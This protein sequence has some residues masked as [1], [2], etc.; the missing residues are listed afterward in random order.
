MVSTVHH[1]AVLYPEIGYDVWRLLWTSGFPDGV[2]WVSF[3][4]ERG[5]EADD[6]TAIILIVY[7]RG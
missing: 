6:L 2:L 5:K 7:G 3:V 1:K 4:V